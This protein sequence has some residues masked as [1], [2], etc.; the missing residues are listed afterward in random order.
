MS[1][2]GL[3]VTDLCFSYTE[4]VPLLRRVSFAVGPGEI[5]CIQ[6]ESGGGKSTLLRIIAGLEHAHSG[7]VRLAGRIL[8]DGSRHVPPE[9]RRIGMVFQDFALFPHLTAA[10]NVAF[11]MNGI[12]RS[13]RERRARTLLERMGL[14][15]GHDR[16]PSELSGG[17][18]QRVAI[19][20]SLAAEP[21]AMLLDEPFAG[22]DTETRDRVRADVLATLRQW[23]IPTILVTHDDGESDRCADSRHH[24][25]GKQLARSAC[26]CDRS[27]P[28]TQPT[29]SAAQWHHHRQVGRRDLPRSRRDSG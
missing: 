21:R 23:S 7:S 8:A 20:R 27:A 12:R 24:L 14:R 10:R 1:D 9:R 2:D 28:T 25:I 22:L 13:E 15:D 11:G 16:Y 26:G 5:C 18:Q 3:E 17:Q 4:S 6:G 19:A 29:P